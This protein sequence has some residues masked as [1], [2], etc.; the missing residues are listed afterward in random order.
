MDNYKELSDEE[1][2]ISHNVVALV[3]SVVVNEALREIKQI[4]IKDST[5]P[6]DMNLSPLDITV[7]SSA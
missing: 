3:C 2:W 6:D 4:L 1:I 5:F 7:L